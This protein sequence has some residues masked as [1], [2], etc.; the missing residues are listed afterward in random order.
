MAADSA[1]GIA[2][3]RQV[4]WRT[5]VTAVVVAGAALV[6]AGIGLVLTL[7][8]TMT[9]QVHD[10]ASIRAEEVATA[11]ANGNQPPLAVGDAEDIIIQVVAPNG[12]VAEASS[13]VAGEPP[14]ADVAPGDSDVVATPLN[15]GDY[16]VVAVDAEGDTVLVGRA[17]DDVAE[18]SRAVVLALVVGIPLV[19]LVVGATTWLLVGPVL[20]RV[21][22][23]DRRQR[24]FVSDASHEL[25]SPIAAIRQHAEVALA[26]P[27]R[28]TLDGLASPVLAEAIRLQGLVEDLLLLARVDERA[29]RL[30]R[31][32]VDVDDL[33]LD[34]IRRL[35]AVTP[36]QVQGTGVGAGRVEGDPRMLVRV[37]R[38][39]SDNAA[40]HARTAI[41]FSVATDRTGSVEVTVDDDG[42]GIPPA[43]RERVF[44]RFVRLDEARARDGGGSGLGLAIVAEVVRAHGGT[45]SFDESDLGGAR[46]RIRLPGADDDG[47]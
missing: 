2:R 16:L 33:A 31:Q 43:D 28:S 29:L 37:L 34:E 20:D 38:N 1:G 14:I 40:R 11:L 36:M 17:L 6:V 22:R 44:Q 39:A 41:A 13:N 12:T 27:D 5:T 9:E 30:D 35:R 4:R 46:L 24:Q 10:G 15:D 7:R 3:L 26:H 25:R 8:D 19:L 23:S 42:P 45:A 47:S 32:A 21:E 18:T